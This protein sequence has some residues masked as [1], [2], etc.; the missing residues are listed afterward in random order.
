MD[1]NTV[2]Q[3]LFSLDPMGTGCVENE[4]EDEYDNVAQAI[5]QGLAQGHG[6]RSTVLAVF[7][8]HFWDGCL[9]EGSRRQKLEQIV[10]ALER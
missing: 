3:L 5:A 4:L 6:V 10:A 9:L 1:E 7:D 2:N 8:A